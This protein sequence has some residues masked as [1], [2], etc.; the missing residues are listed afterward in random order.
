MARRKAVNE[1]S[2][3]ILGKNL[4]TVLLEAGS[5]VQDLL[6]ELDYR[7]GASEVVHVNGDRIENTRDVELEDGDQVVISTK[8]DAGLN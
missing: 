6:D 1:I 8:K 3:V 2:F 4:E 7:L 5:T